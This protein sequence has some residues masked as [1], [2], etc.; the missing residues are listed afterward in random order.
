MSASTLVQ[1]LASRGW[2]LALAESCTGGMIAQ[3]LT[4]VAG[5]SA[6]FGL[7]VVSYS[8]AMKSAV[9]GVPK[10][11]I[12]Q[13]GAVSAACVGAMVDGVQGLSSAELCAAVS[14]ISGPSGATPD[15]PVGTV[16]VGLGRHQERWQKRFQFDGDRNAVR[17]ATSAQ[18]F[19]G[20]SQLVRGQEP[21]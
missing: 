8:N 14:G 20:L 18:V 5:A 10:P 2:S 19:V 7:A 11:L 17:R 21:W 9:L 13:H 4:E 1:E 16:W 3:D 6:V 15:K 12:E